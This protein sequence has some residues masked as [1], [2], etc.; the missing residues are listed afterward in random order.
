[1]KTA[2]MIRLDH[3][4]GD[5]L[6]K[7]NGHIDRNVDQYIKKNHNDKSKE[8]VTHSLFF[9][10]PRELQITAV[11]AAKRGAPALR[12]E[13]NDALEVQKAADLTR[14]RIEH[15]RQLDNAK[16]EYI[17]AWDLIEIY[18]SERGWKKLSQARRVMNGLPSERARLRAV[19][20]QI[21]IQV[22]G[23]GWED[24]AHAWLKGNVPYNSAELMEHFVNVVLSMTEERGVPNEPP[25]KFQDNTTKYTLGTQSALI[26]NH[27]SMNTKTT[28]Q[29]K[30]EAM[31]ER[32]RREVEGETDRDA[33]LQTHSM[34][35]VDETLVGFPIEY[36][37]SYLDDDGGEY[38]A[39][40]DGVVERIISTEKRMVEIR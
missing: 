33:N 37:F 18:H 11:L 4:A 28:E 40:C 36:C 16:E 10:L 30:A 22:N 25:L 19:K 2:G 17:K 13:H 5:G 1:M 29:I 31:V 39:W 15:E 14:K 3:A 27:A 26:V 20:E 24:V 23:F 8:N 7:F 6:W 12:K 9:K 32:A 34:P 38:H 21:M 35:D